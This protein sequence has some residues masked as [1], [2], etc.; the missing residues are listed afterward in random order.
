MSASPMFGLHCTGF[1]RLGSDD[2]DT[3]S[4]DDDWKQVDLDLVVAEDGVRGIP[5]P[6]GFDFYDMH[7]IE[8]RE[9]EHEYQYLAS[10]TPP[11]SSDRTSGISILISYSVEGLRRVDWH[12]GERLGEDRAVNVSTGQ[13][14]GAEYSISKDVA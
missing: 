8:P 3:R 4:Q 5:L 11:S 9:D 12:G 13:V 1:Q 10:L 6:N 7:A 2:R 14:I